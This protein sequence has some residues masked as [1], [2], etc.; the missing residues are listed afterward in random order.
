MRILERTMGS[1]PIPEMVKQIDAV[2]EAFSADTRKPFALRPSFP[3]G[4][5]SPSSHSSPPRADV[6]RPPTLRT[7]SIDTGLDAVAGQHSQVSYASH[8]ITP[9]VSAGP[10][11]LKSDSPALQSLAMMNASQS[12]QPPTIRH[13]MSTAEGAPTWNPSRIFEY[14]IDPS[15]LTLT[16]TLTPESQD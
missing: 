9:P 2:R 3:Y 1:W 15:P 6:F 8:P 4:S 12:S 13:D 5:P 14:E 7:T 10:R 16:L 11:D